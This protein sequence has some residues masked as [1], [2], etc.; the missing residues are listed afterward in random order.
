MKRRRF[1]QII[2][3]AAA[4]PTASRAEM[5][6][7][8]WR[9]TALG[10]DA[11][12]ELH[13]PDRDEGE[14]LVDACVGEVAR[15]EKIFSLY[16]PDS[17]ICRLNRAGMLEQPPVELVELL[18]TS[19]AIHRGTAGAFD[20]TVQPLWELYA[21]HFS[22]ADADPAGPPDALRRSALA[23]VDGNALSIGADRICFGK[24]G[25]AVTLNGIAQGY[26]TDRVVELLRAAGLR[27]CL[28][29]MGETRALGPRA[30]GTPWRVGLED[31]VFPGHVSQHIGLSGQAIA[32]SGA[33][34]LRFDPDGR[35]NHLF[36]PRTGQCSSTFLSVSVMASTAT[37]ADALSTAVCL[38]SPEEARAVIRRFRARA[39]LT[40]PD[41][42]RLEVS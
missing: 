36:D 17:A 2:A 13:C 32:T 33:Y 4:L 20:P 7:V 22:E 40:F 28:V 21:A 10:A 5:T 23:R 3:A 27:H 1:V 30:D 18:S 29:D 12:L 19:A 15:L 11:M 16:R 35:F 24:S 31:P 8:R 34:G 39:F 6:A 41:A 42:S 38:A 14:R 9:G 26:I 37:L 25:M